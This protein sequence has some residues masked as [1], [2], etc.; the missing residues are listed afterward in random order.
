MYFIHSCMFTVGD[1]RN[2]FVI[3]NCIW[4][5]KNLKFFAM[6]IVPF[7]RM[8]CLQSGLW[9]ENFG[10]K[11][12]QTVI[13]KE[14]GLARK[15]LFLWK[16]S[17]KYPVFLSKEAKLKTAWFQRWDCSWVRV[18]SS[19]HSRSFYRELSCSCRLLLFGC[20]HI[21][22]GR[23]HCPVLCTRVLSFTLVPRWFL[24][25]IF[26]FFFLWSKFFVPQV[27]VFNPLVS[28]PDLS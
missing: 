3:K 8:T 1:S 5:Q 22:N 11:K 25:P 20:G 18:C 9:R 16:N 10:L 6:K 17:K 28:K 4:W 12:N 24:C 2:Q 23:G 27:L 14:R 15:K 19:S 13:E 7:H 21:S 26:F